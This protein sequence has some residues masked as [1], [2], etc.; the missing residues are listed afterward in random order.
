M[1]LPEPPAASEGSVVRRVAV[2][3]VIVRDDRVLL[4]RSRVGDVKFPGGGV[5]ADEGHAEA[6]AREVR[7]ET[8]F[9]VSAIGSPLTVVAESHPD[10][11][12]PTT[13]FEMESHYLPAQIADDQAAPQPTE[14]ERAAGLSPVWLTWH[15]AIAANERVLASGAAMP[16]TERETRVLRLLAPDVS[17]APSR[18]C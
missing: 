7:E 2:R 10:I 16:W 12:D 18:R 1:S 11:F 5:E 8:G 9:A 15:E 3:A 17:G 14:S 13:M 4:L 6:L